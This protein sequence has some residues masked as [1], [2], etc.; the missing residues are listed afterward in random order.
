MPVII[1][2]RHTADRRGV[3]RVVQAHGWHTVLH[4]NAIGPGKRPEVLIEGTILLHDEDHMLDL[5]L[6]LLEC[7]GRAHLGR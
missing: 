4:G 5:L 3:V 7:D 2:I 6:R 1:F